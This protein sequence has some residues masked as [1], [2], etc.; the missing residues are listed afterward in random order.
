MA[1]V[2]VLMGAESVGA[3]PEI[4]RIGVADLKDALARGVDDF[5]AMPTH[6]VFLCLIYPVVGVLLGW[7]ISGM[8]WLPLLYP[9]VTGFALLGPFAAIGLYEIS[10]QREQGLAVD[11]RSAFDV[12]LSPS[13]GAI[14]AL[15][16]LLLVIFVIWLAVAQSIYIAH[17]GY[18]PEPSIDEFV[19]RVL[20]TPEGHSLFIVGNLTGFLF[21]LLVLMISVVSFPLL[22]DRD[23]GA[24]EAVLTSVRAVRA[25]PVTMAI[26][27]LIVAGLLLLGSLPF[28]AGLAVVMPVLGHATWHLYRKLI[29][30]APGPRPE[31]PEWP[32]RRRHYA[33]QFPAAIFAG[34][35]RPD[36]S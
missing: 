15:G 12:Y 3:Q 11:L 26:W 21:A 23:V 34:E 36:R 35:E 8:G 7:F 29:K 28:L 17:F 5:L 33:A 6:A 22:L 31:R 9:L 30:P 13:F 32:K 16:L 4:R 1:Q 2:H 20:T 27:G 19:S 24:V 10:R 25:N 14:A 18:G